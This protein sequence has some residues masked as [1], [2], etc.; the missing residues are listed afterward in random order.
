MEKKYKTIPEGDMLRIIALKDFLNIKKGDRGGL[1]DNED[2]LS[3]EG[4]C[5]IYLTA[6]V[7][8]DARVYDNAKVWRF[9]KVS[10]NAKVYGD[11]RVYDYAM[12]SDCACV[13]GKAMISD[14][15]EVYG[16]AVISGNAFVCKKARV[17]EN[18]K[19]YG[20]AQVY[21]D[22]EVC[23]NV[24]LHS[25]RINRYGITASI[26]N[27]KDYIILATGKE[28]CVFSSNIAK[29]EAITETAI[30]YINNIQTIRQIYGEKI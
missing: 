5:W 15:V 22:V 24:K 20:E 14:G 2:N 9:A 7:S 11:A 3:Q 17:Y 27:N 23:G 10:G 1:I 12:I 4:D 26:E 30:D 18:A 13:S 21:G 25:P 28:F 8:G 16:D 19:V 29:V 6:K